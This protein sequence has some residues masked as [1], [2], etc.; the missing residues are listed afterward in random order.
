VWPEGLGKLKK[1]NYLIGNRTHDLKAC[2]IMPHSTDTMC[3]YH[4]LYNYSSIYTFWEI[5]S[6]KMRIGHVACIEDRRTYTNG[7]ENSRAL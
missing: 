4:D 6:R 5:K 7:N 3:S 2:K 1:S